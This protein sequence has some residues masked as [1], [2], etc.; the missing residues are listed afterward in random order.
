M[1]LGLAKER[2]R[3]IPRTQGWRALCKSHRHPTAGEVRFNQPNAQQ[4]LD[5]RREDVAGDPVLLD[6]PGKLQQIG[7]SAVGIGR[8][9]RDHMQMI[10]RS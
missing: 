5:V 8:I 9:A 4:H 10:Y 7:F 3:Q 2:R 1:E 6:Q